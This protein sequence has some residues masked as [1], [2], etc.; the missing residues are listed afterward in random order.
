MTDQTE[1]WTNLRPLLLTD[2]SDEE[3]LELEE[4]LFTDPDFYERL[5]AAED[6]LIDDYVAGELSAHDRQR[7]ESVYLSSPSHRQDVR[8]AKAIKRYAATHAEQS[9]RTSTRKRSA[10]SVFRSFFDSLSLDSRISLAA[11]ALVIIAILGYLAFRALEARHQVPK[12]GDGTATRDTRPSVDVP[13]QGNANKNESPVITDD[14][15]QGNQ[16]RRATRN[17]NKRGPNQERDAM[18][19]KGPES[20]HIYSFIILPGGQVRG[21]GDA[22]KIT[23]PADAGSA[24]IQLPLIGTND[25]PSY[26]ASLRTDD[27]K[28]VREWRGLRATPSDAGKVVKVSV[29]ATLLDAGRYRMI[30]AGISETGES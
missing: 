22:N 30:I 25:Y 23:L 14:Q 6:D 7:F 13:D 27:D 1:E 24:Q 5:R 8:I 4:R 16:T 17:E 15:D 9:R 26:S 11:G 21:G 29:P 2:T 10:V 28:T 19:A 12:P 20:G 18:V 3:R